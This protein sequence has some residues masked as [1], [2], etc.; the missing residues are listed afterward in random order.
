M[1]TLFF[2]ISKI[3]GWGLSP[4]NFVFILICFAMG[5][6]MKGR[7]ERAKWLLVV[8]VGIMGCLGVVPISYGLVQRLENA[9]PNSKIDYDEVAG[10]IVL[11][12]GIDGGM[13]LLER[14]EVS[15]NSAAERMTTTAQ[16]ARKYPRLKIIFS[17]FSGSL[18]PQGMPESAA[19]QRFFDSEGIASDR[20]VYESRSRNTVENARFSQ[21]LMGG[22]EGPW[23]LLTSASHMR[24]AKAAFEKTGVTVIPHS[25][26]YQTCATIPWFKFNVSQ[27]NILAEI[28][29]HE[30]VG[31]FI[32]WVTGR[33]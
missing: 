15:L 25:V 32:Y 24:R 18:F 26:D 2:V 33:A 19:A 31:Q 7:F 4:F 11:G 13:I 10:I 23:V 6:L 17:G 12:G 30:Y 16:L 27:G 22:V 29:I 9:V 1:A 8:V 5:F 14:D 28:A 3:I 20:V 21:P